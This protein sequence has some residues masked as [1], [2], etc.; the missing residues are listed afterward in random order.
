MNFVEDYNAQE[1]P[2]YFAPMPNLSQ[3]GFAM[4]EET[5][6]GVQQLPVTPLHGDSLEASPARGRHR[7]RNAAHG[8]ESQCPA[9]QEIRSKKPSGQRGE[10]ANSLAAQLAQQFP[11]AKIHIGAP[12]P[13]EQ[14]PATPPAAQQA[15]PAAAA[16][17]DMQS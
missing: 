7:I 15:A 9:T 13:R 2:C 5:F 16:P 1:S 10:G 17:D 6:H 8:K 3:I 4:P 12:E 11:G 14:P